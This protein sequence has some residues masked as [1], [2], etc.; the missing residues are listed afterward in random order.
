MFVGYSEK[1]KSYQ[2]YIPGYHQIELSRYFTFDEDTTF[3][4]SNK[5]KEDEKEHETPKTA[6]GPK[7][8]RNE[9]EHMPQDHDI[10]EPQRPE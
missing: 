8:I 10:T 3:R 5:Y 2:I 6:E 1:S 7:P 4:K 9:E